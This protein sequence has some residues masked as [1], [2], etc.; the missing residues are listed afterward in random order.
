M[1]NSNLVSRCLNGEPPVIYGDDQQ[2]RGF[3]HV[4]DVVDAN[5]TLLDSDAVDGDVLNIGSSV[6]ISVQELAETVRDQL[7]PELGIDYESAREA[8][9]DY[10]HASVEKAGGVIGYEPSQTIAADV[11][12]FIEWCRVN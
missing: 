7:G 5:R 6:N 3:T 12:E 10:T 1:A 2:T 11:G 8:D 4:G 9:A